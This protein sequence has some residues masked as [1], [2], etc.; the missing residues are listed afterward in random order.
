VASPEDKKINEAAWAVAILGEALLIGKGEEKGVTNV[1]GR[2]V[3]WWPFYLRRE[4][5]KIKVLNGGS[6]KLDVD[7]RYTSLLGIDQKARE[8]LEKTVKF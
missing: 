4:G 3:F 2:G 6:K 7:V 5:E 1:T 8:A